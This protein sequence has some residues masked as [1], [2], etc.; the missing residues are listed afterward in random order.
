MTFPS[1]AK[2]PAFRR[3]ESALTR[4]RLMQL[5]PRLR[6]ELALLGLLIAG[7]LFWQ[8]RVPL[9]GLVRARGPLSALGAVATAWLI[10]A[11][12]GGGLAGGEHVRRL[13]T[14]PRGPE[15]L[16]LPIP[17]DALERHLAWQ[18]RS[19]IAWLGVPALGVLVA[20]I[21]LVPWWWLPPLAVAFVALLA[22]A[23]V[24]GCAIGYRLVLA[25]TAPRPGLHPVERV[26]A[27]AAP[28]ATDRRVAP[29]AWRR[30]PSW[31]TLAAKDLTLTGRMAMLRRAAALPL[32][33]WLASLLAWQLPGETALQHFVAFAL[34]L[35]AAAGL[36][37]WLV[38]LS[39]SDPFTVLRVLPVGVMTAWGA[40]AIW[41][42]AMVVA[43]GIGHAVVARPLSPGALNVFLVWSGAA[44][45]AIAVL[46]VNYGVTLFPR[47]DV[48]RRMLGL[49]LGLA[50]AASIMLPLSGW[51][52][53]LTAVLHS[54]RR[55]PRWSRLEEA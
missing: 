53:L 29:A 26:L 43:L 39:G 2:I 8:V 31:L 52:V 40:R 33:F 11:A 47:A 18:S 55:L 38:A 23:G 7:F 5:D 9:D 14:G 1:T 19:R 45:I 10:L 22:T 20:A 6:I 4:R 41:A 42:P 34:A 50:M 24:A 54:A 15:W 16:A 37:E 21:G 51:V 28:R 36:A 13:R 3:L 35:L 44:T 17:P 27:V 30:L 25:A 48:A 32:G 49:S 12:I 46:G